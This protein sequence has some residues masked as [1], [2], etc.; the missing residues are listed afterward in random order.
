MW[1]LRRSGFIADEARW[2]QAILRFRAAVPLDGQGGQA[3]IP[4]SPVLLA[5]FEGS[6][7]PER[8]ER[9]AFP[10]CRGSFPPLHGAF[11]M[12]NS[13]E[14]RG[15]EDRQAFT[16]PFPA[17]RPIRKLGKACR[18]TR[19]AAFAPGNGLMQAG[20]ET[21]PVSLSYAVVCASHFPHGKPADRRGMRHSPVSLRSSQRGKRADNGGMRG[22]PV[23]DSS[24]KWIHRR[25]S[26][27]ASGNPALQSRWGEVAG[28]AGRSLEGQTR[29]EPRGRS[30]EYVGKL[31]VSQ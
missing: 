5:S 26:L 9:N 28:H 12:G 11:P 19:N 17:A 6:H 2:L 16:G 10:V 15:K 13:S 25:R 3:R 1:R 14:S 29:N 30:Y 18:Q 8:T 4:A 20:N 22:F 23:V 31:Y 7:A 24:A 27:L 21:F